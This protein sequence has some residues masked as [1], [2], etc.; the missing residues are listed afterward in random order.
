MTLSQVFSVK[1]SIQAV[2]CTSLYRIQGK[3]LSCPADAVL[4]DQSCFELNS[5]LSCPCD[6]NVMA[7][8]SVSAPSSFCRAVSSQYT[9]S[10]I[11][12]HLNWLHCSFADAVTVTVN[13]QL[14][15]VSFQ[16]RQKK[17]DGGLPASRLGAACQRHG[18]AG[19]AGLLQTPLQRRRKRDNCH[20]QASHSLTHTRA[21]RQAQVKGMHICT[22]CW[23]V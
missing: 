20:A 23:L 11:V 18:P 19:P 4:P 10:A 3:L 1:A 8:Q 16:S 17:R 15:Q 13:C 5:L 22:I 21:P 2:V 6:T 12:T 7:C 9:G 14:L